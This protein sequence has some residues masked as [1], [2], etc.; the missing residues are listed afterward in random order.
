ML[1]FVNILQIVELN[2]LEIMFTE[3]H[4][5]LHE[6]DS[7]RKRFASSVLKNLGNT[8]LEFETSYQLVGE[9]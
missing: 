4:S 1:Y 2:W 7:N 5:L 9:S 3:A 6:R 8:V